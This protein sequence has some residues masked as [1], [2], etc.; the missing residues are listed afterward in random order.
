M[1]RVTGPDA[2]PAVRPAMQAY[3]VPT[4]F[5]LVP[6]GLMLLVAYDLRHKSEFQPR[7]DGKKPDVLDPGL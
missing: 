5:M 3:P 2:G 6:R 1:V 7:D 4:G